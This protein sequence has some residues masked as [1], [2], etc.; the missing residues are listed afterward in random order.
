[1]VLPEPRAQWRREVLVGNGLGEAP[2]AEQHQHERHQQCRRSPPASLASPV[3]QTTLAPRLRAFRCGAE[4]PSR[5]ADCRGLGG[6]STVADRVRGFVTAPA[7]GDLDTGGPLGTGCSEGR[8]L[9]VGNLAEW[10]PLH[11]ARDPDERRETHVSALQRG[12]QRAQRHH[13]RPDLGEDVPDTV[14]WFGSLP[15]DARGDYGERTGGT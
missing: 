2:A 7:R 11:H 4:G 8:A 5:G 9:E 12:L 1:M 14:V 3:L 6:A 15:G 13:L 10:L